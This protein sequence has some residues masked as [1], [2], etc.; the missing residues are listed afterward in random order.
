MADD[1]AIIETFTD[2]VNHYHQVRERDGID[3]V[4]AEWARA[5]IAGARILLEKAFGD[6][7]RHRIFAEVRQRT[8]KGIPHRIQDWSGW[9]SEA[10]RER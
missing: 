1:T 4:S 8:G 9:D 5:E 3:S 6:E 10:Q 2:L 7:T